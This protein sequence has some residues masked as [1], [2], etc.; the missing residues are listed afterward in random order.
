MSSEGRPPEGG[1]PADEVKRSNRR[2]APARN[3]PTVRTQLLEWLEQRRRVRRVRRLDE[4]SRRS[5]SRARLRENRAGA[6]GVEGCVP[7]LKP[8]SRIGAFQPMLYFFIVKLEGQSTWSH[9]RLTTALRGPCCR[10]SVPPPMR[11]ASDEQPCRPRPTITPPASGSRTGPA[12]S[13][14]CQSVSVQ[15]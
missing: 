13:S 9:V 2:Q 1:T 12:T 4:Q 8:L 10:R 15:S 6:A 14:T 7:R 3:K 5:G 11:R